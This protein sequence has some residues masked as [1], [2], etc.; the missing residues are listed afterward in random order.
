MSE[1]LLLFT[2]DTFENV[3]QSAA[4]KTLFVDFW[5]TWCGPCRMLSPLFEAAADDYADEAL[6]AKCNVDECPKPAGQ[7]NI[8]GIPTILVFK[9]GALVNQHTGGMSKS[10]LEAF[11]EENL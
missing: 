9:N 10:Q 4:G 1:N 2:D 5:A 6:F 3:I 11:I 8:R 7:F